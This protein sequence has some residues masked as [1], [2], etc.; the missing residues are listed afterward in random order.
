[1]KISLVTLSFNQREYLAE[2]I[3][4][5]LSQEYQETEYIVVDPGSNDGS[6]QL[7]ES[8]GTKIAHLIFQPDRG[9]AEGL[10]NGFAVATG[11]VF[12]FLNADDILFPSSLNQV[13]GFFKAHS[14]CDIVMGNG[15]TIDSLGRTIKHYKARDFSVR[16]FFYGGS[17]WLQQATFFKADL[18]R[19]AGG[20]NP[21]N[22]TSW[23]GELLLKMAS[24]GAKIGYLNADIGAFRIH[25]KSIS[26]S[27][28]LN[29]QYQQDCRR[30]FRELNGRD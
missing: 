11:D 5:V 16:R 10:N 3:D 7:I 27:G 25:D 14:E 23:D 24:L 28:R 8:Y 18:Y 22:R 9:A 15:Y 1:M 26:G 6:R 13:S 17:E 2:A 12:G 29:N 4:S 21:E 19:R 30:V 20:F